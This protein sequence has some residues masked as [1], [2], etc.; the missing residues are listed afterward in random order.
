MRLTQVLA[1]LLNFS[2]ELTPPQFRNVAL[3]R[4][5]TPIINPRRTEHFYSRDEVITMFAGNEDALTDF[6]DL[7]S[8]K[9]Q[10]AETKAQRDR[11]VAKELKLK[12]WDPKKLRSFIVCYFCGKRRCIYSPSDADFARGSA[13]LKAKL[14][15]L[16]DRYSCG[17]LIFGDEDDMSKIIVQKLNLTCESQIEPSYYKNDGRTLKL[18]PICVHCGESES[19]AAGSFLLGQE[20]LR[21]RNLRVVTNAYPFVSCAFRVARRLSRGRRKIN[22]KHER[23]RHVQCNE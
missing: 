7:P 19:G 14:E 21:Q 11:A 16:S 15:S 13:A 5:P 2:S 1:I 18:K 6:S 10:G 9:S 22:W 17:D 12:S 20:Q 8:Y 4:Q 23:S 3:Q